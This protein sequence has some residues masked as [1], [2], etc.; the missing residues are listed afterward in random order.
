MYG[1][2]RRNLLNESNPLVMLIAL[3]LILFVILNFIQIAY[4]LGNSELY[5]YET[6]VLHHFT[7][8]G[9]FTS[10]LYKP[11]TFFTN[12]FV[13]NGIWQLIGNML[14]LWGFGFLLQDLAGEKHTAPLYL[15]GGWIGAI[16]WI[17]S[18]NTIPA[19][20]TE[21]DLLVLSGSGAAVMAIAVAGT[22]LAPQY[23]VFPLIGGG[24][25]IWI[26]TLIYILIDFA[27][28]AGKAFPFHLS[29]LAGAAIGVF[30]I[31]SLRKGID[32]GKPL[33]QLYNTALNL[34][35]P[36]QRKKNK[37][38]VVKD[39]YFYD[40]KGAKPFHKKPNITQKRIDELLDKINQQGLEALTEEEKDFLKKAGTDVT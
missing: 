18:L 27:G 11:W 7:M 28:L 20:S 6:E 13:H 30:Y 17:L 14:F 34:F 26:I 40:T 31:F 39:D 35:S 24:I 33:H 19:F 21:A 10:F 38:K 29:H 8:P 9:N 15:Y 25:P 12:I 16:I 32:P 2:Q 4:L 22:M 3:N 36:N 5:E 23:R 37:L 1:K